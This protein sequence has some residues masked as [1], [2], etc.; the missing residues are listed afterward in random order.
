M[1][2]IMS[3]PS[4]RQLRKRGLASSGESHR[5]DYCPSAGHRVAPKWGGFRSRRVRGRLLGGAVPRDKHDDAPRLS[6]VCSRRQP[7]RWRMI[8]SSLVPVGIVWRGPIS[9]ERRTRARREAA[10]TTADQGRRACGSGRPAQGS[11]WLQ[12]MGHSVRIIPAHFVKQCVK[13]KR[14]NRR[15]GKC[16][17]CGASRRCDSWR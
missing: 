2:N 1:A 6:R 15:S 9:P 16:R 8:A 7:N 11:Q 10:C 13:S 14:R 12:A 5:P 3:N 17:S 4:S